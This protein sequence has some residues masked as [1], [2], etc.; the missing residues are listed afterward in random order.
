MKIK[1]NFELNTTI[2][3]LIHVFYITNFNI[4]PYTDSYN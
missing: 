1:N 4:L 3:I 2:L